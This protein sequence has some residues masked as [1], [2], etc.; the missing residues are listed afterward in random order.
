MDYCQYEHKSMVFKKNI[1]NDKQT[2]K[3]S[4]VSTIGLR[5]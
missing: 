3:G 4:L 5:V 2:L 1:D